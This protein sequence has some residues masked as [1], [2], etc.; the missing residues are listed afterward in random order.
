MRN[1]GLFC[2]S[3]LAEET[4]VKYSQYESEFQKRMAFV[5]IACLALKKMKAPTQVL[6]SFL[7]II[8]R[9]SNDDRIYVKKAVNWALRQIGKKNESLRLQALQT[10]E[11]ILSLN[12]KSGN[13]I[14][15]DAIN[16]LKKRSYNY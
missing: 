9:E 16:E 15:K 8:V 1:P 6:A 14:S 10:C 4:L 11:Q 3:E 2:K 13:W 7:P 12:T 5:L